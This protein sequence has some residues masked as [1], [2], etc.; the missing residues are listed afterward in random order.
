MNK[1]EYP[2]CL[3]L[4][5]DDWEK[6]GKR[7]SD[8]FPNYWSAIGWLL[9]II[10]N[11]FEVELDTLSTLLNVRKLH[12]FVE[13]DSSVEDSYKNQLH[14]WI[15]KVYF[16]VIYEFCRIYKE[17]IDSDFHIDFPSVRLSKG[18]KQSVL[19]RFLPFVNEEKENGDLDLNVDEEGILTL[20]NM[21]H[22][23]VDMCG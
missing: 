5:R 3:G 9:S 7:S 14:D 17:K 23:R 8:F 13:K 21:P 15:E 19:V 16:H 12:E 20:I 10:K 1:V 18:K 11:K 2:T 22:L 6:L 4:T